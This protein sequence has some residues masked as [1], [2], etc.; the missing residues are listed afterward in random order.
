VVAVPLFAVSGRF[1]GEVLT[2]AATALPALGVGWWGGVSLH[3]RVAAEP[4]RRLVLALLV[5]SA[6]VAGT[7][8]LRG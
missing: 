3:G 5:V 2:A 8:A 1:T 4:F 7:G 6:L